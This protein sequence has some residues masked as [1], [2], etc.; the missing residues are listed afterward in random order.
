[1][2]MEYIVAGLPCLASVGK[3]A[4]RLAKIETARLWE[5]IGGATCLEDGKCR[6]GEGLWMGDDQE[7]DRE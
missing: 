4:P 5:Y 1:M 7:R 6:M 3:E 2:Y